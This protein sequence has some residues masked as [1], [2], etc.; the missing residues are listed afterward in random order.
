MIATK[1]VA[2]VQQLID[3][4]N[5]QNVSDYLVVF[6]RLLTSGHLQKN[7]EFYSSF[8]DGCLSVKEFCSHEVEPMYKESD[9]IHIIALTEATGVGV[10]INYLDRGQGGKVTVHLFP[11]GCNPK[12]H[13]LYRPGH[14]DI[15]YLK[16]DKNDF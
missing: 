1:E 16:S 7:S 9:H 15:L 12:L 14:Y 2:T 4:F 10:C 3:L 6:M 8:I 11:D 5:D 13:L